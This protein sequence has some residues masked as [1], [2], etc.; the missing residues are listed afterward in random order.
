ML[1]STYRDISCEMKI[2]RERQHTSCTLLL[3]KC[4][5]EALFCVA[6][7]G[8]RILEAPAA[9]GLGEDAAERSG[10]GAKSQL[11]CF[12][13]VGSMLIVPAC[14]APIIVEQK[15]Y[16]TLHVF[17]CLVLLIFCGSFSITQWCAQTADGLTFFNRD[18]TSSE[19]DLPH[20]PA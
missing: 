12:W 1:Q 9:G 7:D 2:G 19:M 18:S 5:A 4:R 11:G 15:L 10:V 20:D 8:E 14:V 17:C 6:V 13:K 16:V 3:A